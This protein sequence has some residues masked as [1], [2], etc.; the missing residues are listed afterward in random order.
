MCLH[1]IN[2]IFQ[3]T[4][5]GSV[6]AYLRVRYKFHCWCFWH[7]SS[8]LV[9]VC[10]RKGWGSVG[11][12]HMDLVSGYLG[13]KVGV[14]RMMCPRAPSSYSSSSDYSLTL[15]RLVVRCYFW[16]SGGTRLHV[17]PFPELRRCLSWPN[18]SC[19]RCHGL[20]F[21]WEEQL[22]TLT[23]PS[24]SWWTNDTVAYEWARPPLGLHEAP[25]HVNNVLMRMCAITVINTA[26]RQATVRSPDFQEG[27]ALHRS[28]QSWTST[29]RP[30]LN[31]LLWIH[32]MD[33]K[34]FFFFFFSWN[35]AWEVSVVW[36][37]CIER[38]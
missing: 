7:Q 20:V 37:R 26:Q 12:H 31:R 4:P 38:F 30:L 16:C 19:P 6:C 34:M 36:T 29:E 27:F 9:H 8:I 14:V 3:A 25:G 13:K 28:R 21:G 33:N 5:E 1:L 11:A 18:G 35:R 10:F 22:S 23:R 2:I 17:L 24:S 32:S 15:A